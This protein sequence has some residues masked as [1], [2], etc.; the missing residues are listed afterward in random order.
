[1]VFIEIF[2]LILYLLT[3]FFGKFTWNNKP[4]KN[5]FTKAFLSFLFSSSLS[6]VIGLPILGILYL[7]G[8]IS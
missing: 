5:I 2:F 4:V 8:E 6:L 7:I 3:F 1:M